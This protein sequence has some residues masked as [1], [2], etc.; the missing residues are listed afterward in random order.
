[1]YRII[2]IGQKSVKAKI[3]NKMPAE[4]VNINQPRVDKVAEALSQA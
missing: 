4:P 1:V 3:I 2:L